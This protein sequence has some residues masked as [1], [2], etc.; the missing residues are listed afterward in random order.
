MLN[1]EKVAAKIKLQQKEIISYGTEKAKIKKE[2]GNPKG[3]LILVTSTSPTPYGE[4]KTTLSIGITD[5]LNALGYCSI[6][7][8]REPSLGP[9]FGLKGG[10]TGGGKSQIV[11]KEDINL[12]FTGDIHAIT[13]ANNLLCA[14]LDNHIYQG[15][16]LEIDPATIMIHRCMD[17]ND[18][19]LRNITLDNRKES[20]DIST[21]SEVMA[22]FCLATSLSDLQKRLGEI[23]IAY[24][25]NGKEIYAKDLNVQ[26]AMVKLLEHAFLPNLVQTLEENPVLIHGG[27]FANIAHGCNSIVATSLGLSLADYIVTEAGFGSDMGALKFFD[28]KCRMHHLNPSLV[29][30]NT[31]IR[32]L[33]YNAEDKKSLQSGIQNLV[34]HIENMKRFM[35]NVCVV[36]NRF[37]DDSE[38]DINYVKEF[39][40][41]QNVPFMISDCYLK[42]SSGG[43]DMASKIVSLC[44]TEPISYP[45]ELSDS[46]Q[47]KIEKICQ[48]HYGASEVEFSS[49]VIEKMK[50][51]DKPLPICI[52][53]TP[54]SISDNPNLLGFPKNFKMRVTD[55]KL[56]NGAGFITVYMGN[57]MTMPGLPKKP[58]YLN[59]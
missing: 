23:L 9:V 58:N 36:L 2:I 56:N 33:K 29:V 32:S 35:K 52:A 4:G 54:Y 50:K 43:I 49:L 34:F 28:I 17:M 1:I 16:E 19:A 55:I 14:A 42:G 53:K 40:H 5:S 10:A 46:L 30:I 59:M 15:N 25:K 3:H 37:E 24:S 41:S 18:R 13:S 51:L 12:H 26:G 6:A 44:K 7:V 21:A 45:Y 8:L 57:I 20:F 22:I 47:C 31:T 27:P 39:C 48:K 11:P 38:V